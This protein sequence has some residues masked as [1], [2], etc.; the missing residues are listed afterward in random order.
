MSTLS[1]LL[2]WS[3]YVEL[4]PIKDINK[5]NYYIKITEQQNLGVINLR[6]RIKSNEYERLDDKTKEKLIENKENEIQDFIK[7]P[8]IIKNTNYEE[9][10]EKYYKN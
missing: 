1:T 5:I 10:T 7:H 4:L 2:S 9:I 6:K 8:I 3:H